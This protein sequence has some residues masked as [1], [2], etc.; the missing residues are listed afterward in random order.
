MSNSEIPESVTV[1]STFGVRPLAKQGQNVSRKRQIRA[2]YTALA[3]PTS[4]YLMTQSPNSLV[5]TLVAP[6]IMR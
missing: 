2:N 4:M 5:F 1:E 6:S 3:T